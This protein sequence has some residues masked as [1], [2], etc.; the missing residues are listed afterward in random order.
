MLPPICRPLRHTTVPR[1]TAPG[2][3]HDGATLIQLLGCPRPPRARAALRLLHLPVPKTILTHQQKHLATMTRH[4]AKAKPTR[5]SFDSGVLEVDIAGPYP[6]ALSGFQYSLVAVHTFS[7]FTTVT[8]LRTKAE[9]YPAIIRLIADIRAAGGTISV[10]RPDLGGEFTPSALA[11]AC[12]SRGV[13]VSYI[14]T[15]RYLPFADRNHRALDATMRTNLALA[16]SFLG[17]RHW[18][19]ARACAAAQHNLMPHRTLPKT[20]YAVFDGAAPPLRTI[21]LFGT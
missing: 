7:Q 11:Y 16:P 21:L 9:A 20:R 14:T 18:P 5:P 17:P 12:A 8:P 1:G 15:D 6:A 2:L 13:S 19:W 3:P 4:P 10:I